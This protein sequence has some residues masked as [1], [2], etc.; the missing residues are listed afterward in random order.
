MKRV[1]EIRFKEMSLLE[2]YIKN[3]VNINVIDADTSNSLTIPL[4]SVVLV[5]LVETLNY[6]W[7]MVEKNQIKTSSGAT[8][9]SFRPKKRRQHKLI[10]KI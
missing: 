9:V 8:L 3:Q 2:F 1:E 10:F 4:E 6:N 5:Y 7:K